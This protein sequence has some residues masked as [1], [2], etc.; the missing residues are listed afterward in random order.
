MKP[1]VQGRNTNCLE[2][3][4]CP[5]CLSLGTFRIEVTSTNIVSDEG[6]ECSESGQEWE[7]KSYCECSDCGHYGKVKDFR[8]PQQ[9]ATKV[10]RTAKKNLPLLV[11]T[12]KTLDG[13]NAL[14][15]R[16]KGAFKGV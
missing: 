1:D 11:G 15:A 16:L 8:L 2:G 4:C 3:M 5:K 9:E 12:L 7:D 6:V 10:M 13:K 14:N